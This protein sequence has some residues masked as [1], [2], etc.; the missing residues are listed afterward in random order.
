VAST[1]P[2]HAEAKLRTAQQGNSNTTVHSA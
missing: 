2:G 1:P